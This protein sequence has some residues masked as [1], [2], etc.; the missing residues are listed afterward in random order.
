MGAALG[1][2]QVTSQEV[3]VEQKQSQSFGIDSKY[4][5]RIFHGGLTN[6]LYRTSSEVS[7]IGVHSLRSDAVGSLRSENR[8]SFLSQ[9][10]VLRSFGQHGSL[11]EVWNFDA[12]ALPNASTEGSSIFAWMDLEEFEDLE[13]AGVA[14]QLIKAWIAR[15]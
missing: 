2:I 12:F 13:A 3:K 1:H 10:S 8:R 7:S 15:E 9:G 6:E 4:I 5:R 14:D 11:M